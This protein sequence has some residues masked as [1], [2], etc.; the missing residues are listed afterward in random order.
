MTV[1]MHSIIPDGFSDSSPRCPWKQS[2]LTESEHHQTRLCRVTHFSPRNWRNET[3]SLGPQCPHLL[4]HPV[5]L[6]FHIHQPTRSHQNP[7]KDLQIRPCR[8]DEFL[9]IDP[10]FSEEFGD[11]DRGVGFGKG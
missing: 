9:R 2:T 5:H 10:Q 3:L 1:Q 7:L 11:A 4:L 8:H 6:P